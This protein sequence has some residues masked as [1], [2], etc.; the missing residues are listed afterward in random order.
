[1][2]LPFVFAAILTGT[3]AVSDLL[4]QGQF[5][6]GNNLPGTLTAPRT[7]AQFYGVDPNH[8]AEIRRGNSAAGLPAGTQ[9]YAG[10]LLSG[11]GFT[12]A[13][14]LGDDPASTLANSTPPAILGTGS[15]RTGNGAGLLFTLLAADS[16][17]PGGTEGV[18]FQFR[19]WDNQ[20]GTITSWSDVAAS[21]G[22]VAAGSSDVHVFDAPFGGGVILPP[23]TS[24]IRSFQLTCVPEPSLIALGALGLG[25][26]LLCRRR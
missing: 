15:F 7:L 9:I 6:W 1:M 20:G 4:A 16:T 24:G 3:V 19:A 11:T 23:F 17:R 22:L 8:P 21:G 12:A 14:Y 2:K 5:L 13:I 18:N 10:P 26:L 25:A